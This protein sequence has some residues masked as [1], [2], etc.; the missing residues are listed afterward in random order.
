[1]SFFQAIRM[2]FRRSDAVARFGNIV[3]LPVAIAVGAI[4]VYV[5]ETV[6]QDKIKRDNTNRAPAWQQREDRQLQAMLNP[7]I[8]QSQS[9]A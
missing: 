6:S 2:V 9:E 4:G 1:M 3:F 8:D 7:T 5:E